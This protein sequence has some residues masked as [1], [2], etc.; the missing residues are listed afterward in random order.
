MNTEKNKW[1]S[2]ISGWLGFKSS[3]SSFSPVILLICLTIS[4]ILWFINALSKN[5][6]TTISHPV[7]YVN[8]PRNRYF[9]NSPPQKL[10]LTVSSTGFTLLRNM[11]TM[12]LAPISLNIADMVKENPESLK[13]LYI[14]PASNIKEIISEQL[15]SSVQL[16][17]VNPGAFTM[18]FDTLS[19]RRVAVSS[20]VEIDLKPRF[21]LISD[22]KLVPALVTVSGSK[23][24]I[25]NIDTIYTEPRIMNN[26]DASFSIEIDLQIPPQVNVEPR[27]VTL[28]A[29][30]DEF[31]EK[32]LMVPVRV[33]NLPGE[34]KMRL[35]PHETE[36]RFSAGLSSFPRIKPDDFELYVDWNDISKK[37]SV[38]KVKISKQPG[39]LQS[40]TISPENV[41][42][43]IEK[44]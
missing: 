13:G 29:S 32:K 38:L 41:E 22:I 26:Q 39:Y 30:I 40:L 33:L 37:T 19:I 42:Y 18:A 24:L 9:V 5:Y 31:T 27:Y 11:M 23:S 36:V 12:S 8:L 28:T 43:L 17:D 16:L 25:E 14:V 34:I 1:Y 7:E 4:T 10:N 2:Y 21:G 6:V 20:K 15:G 44:N 3:G 35:F